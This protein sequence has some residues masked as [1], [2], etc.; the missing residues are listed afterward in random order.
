MTAKKKKINR[1]LEVKQE[2]FW[3]PYVERNIDLERRAEKE[4]NKIKKQNAKLRNNA[5]LGKSIENS[6][7][8]VD[9][10]LV[11]TRK[12]YLKRKRFKEKYSFIM[13]Q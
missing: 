7:N 2:P 12:Q 9:I 10:K 11:T 13:E 6:M 5:T 8:K 3:K 4:G 1:I